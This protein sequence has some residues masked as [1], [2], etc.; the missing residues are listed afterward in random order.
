MTI[1][2]GK[3]GFNIDVNGVEKNVTFDVGP[4]DSPGIAPTTP[5]H[6][7]INVDNEKKDLSKSTKITLGQYLRSITSVNA[8]PNDGTVDET[9]LTD[10]N[11]LP[12]DL[13]SGPINVPSFS[14]RSHIGN[15]TL[16]TPADK[17][18]S[19]PEGHTLDLLDDPTTQLTDFFKGKKFTQK[20]P[21]QYDGNNLLPTVRKDVLPPPLDRYVTSV[22]A[23]NRFTSGA[24]A[25]FRIK[26]RN[27]TGDQLKQVGVMLSLRGSQEF[28]AAFNDRVNPVDAGSVAGALIP[29][30][31]QLGVLKVSTLLLEAKDAL[32]SID[33]NDDAPAESTISPIDGQSWGAL[34][35]VEEQWSGTLNIGMIAMALAMQSALLLAFEGLGA[36]IGMVSNG[37]AS[38]SVSRKPD[39]SY[40]KGSY[41]ATPLSD[42]NNV[43][44]PPDIM[45]ILGIKGTRFPFGDALKVGAAAFFVGGDAAKEGLASQFT[46]A[47]TSAIEGVLSDNSS[48]GYM[49]IVSRVIIRT[50]QTIAAHIEKIVDAFGS[51]PVSGVKSI[52]GLLDI[53][54]RSKLIAAINIFTMLGDAILSEDS[55]SKDPDA[56]ISGEK[57]VFS[58]IDSVSDDAASAAV[59]KNRLRGSN[60]KMKLAWATNRSPSLY[61]IPDSLLTMGLVDNK[62]GSHSGPLGA[63]DPDSRT[64]MFVQDEASRK[65]EGSRI[66]RSSP[67]GDGVDVKKMEELLEAEYVPFYFHDLRT[68]EIISFHAFLTALSDD[69][70]ASWESSDAYGRVDPVK[71]YKS[72]ARRIG[73]SFYIAATDIKDF[74][75]MW[76]KINKLITLVYPQYTKGRLLTDGQNTS[77]VQ[78][79][80][81][82]IGAS[83]L[84]RI[85]LGDLLRSNYSRFALAR[86]FGAADGDM[87]IDQ[88]IKF[89][90]AAAIL[91]DPKARDFIAKLFEKALADPSSKYSLVT[92]GWAS[93]MEP[94]AGGVSAGAPGPSTP[95]QAASMKIDEGDLQYFEFKVKPKRMSNGNLAVEPSILSAADMTS[96]LGID[97]ATA[98]AQANS[99]ENKYNNSTNPN[100]KVIGGVN[101]YA[102]PASQLTIT[103]DTMAK[104]VKEVSSG[105]SAAIPAIDSLSS[106]LDIEKNALVK[107]FRS[108][109]GKGLA[110]VI[111]SMNFDWYDKVTW[112]VRPGHKAPKICK[113]T[114]A[115]TPIHDISPGIDHLGAN[116]APVYPVG[117]A[118][119]Q[120][121][122][123][124]KSG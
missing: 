64:H 110:G 50:G 12:V 87:V 61:L 55:F 70:T 89:E 83:P 18:P 103:R 39:G 123:P 100:T 56:G 1:N 78:P 114:I 2:T 37:G 94:A 4:I 54:K 72:T 41:L 3:G 91:K 10:N 33:G 112:D 6:G 84:V 22:L 118:M 43:G 7:D 47:A 30:P 90:G 45:A 80:S 85:R 57:G 44:F 26:G 107:S 36:M 34:N 77:F 96:K 63:Q 75:E 14:D 38:P 113:V 23:N 116:R 122:D 120:G 16:G 53:I 9:Q 42:P 76:L 59:K 62:L 119:G 97:T 15:T 49:I 109:Q 67:T 8:F 124:D 117:G 88:P 51:N 74:D 20:Q 121:F 99:L 111:E 5:D 48:A 92:A 31:N 60:N 108:V 13:P 28:P 32:E 29:S 82:L 46:S 101:G 105:L 68:N 95:D 11:G 106:F 24:G 98:T 71:I 35:N 86:L 104:L 65:S 52:M 58:N 19:G 21:G 115:F 27:Y 81:Q 102:V 25:S 66:P 73:L 17:R 69:F 40:T 79:F 93:A